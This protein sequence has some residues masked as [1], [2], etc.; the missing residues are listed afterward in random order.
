MN[1]RI[2]FSSLFMMALTTLFVIVPRPALALEGSEKE[3]MKANV[4]EAL[5][6]ARDFKAQKVRE[7]TEN[8]ERELGA[9]DVKK[10]QA[11]FQAEQEKVREGYVKERNSQPSEFLQQARLERQFD[12]K[13]LI[14]DREMIK[15]RLEYLRERHEVENIIKKRGYIDEKQEYGL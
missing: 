8:R 13:K 15:S 2:L 5:N 6:R 11:E 4:R 7:V 3:Q 10:E 9:K 14:E 1:A 12:E